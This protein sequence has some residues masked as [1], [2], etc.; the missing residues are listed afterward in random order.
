MYPFFK[1]TEALIGLKIIAP[2]VGVFHQVHGKKPD[3]D[4]ITSEKRKTLM[5]N[6]R[7]LN[8][9]LVCYVMVKKLLNLLEPEF[10]Q[11]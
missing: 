1:R 5:W 6:Q 11:W 7:N 2:N 3:K 9:L 8:F 4:N 10:S